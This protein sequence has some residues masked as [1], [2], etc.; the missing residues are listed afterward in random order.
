[1][2]HEL[3]D[4]LQVALQVK[5]AQWSLRDQ[6]TD[7]SRSLS[8][9]SESCLRWAD[10]IAHALATA[11]VPPDGRVS[12]VASSPNAIPLE[13]RWRGE[14]EVAELAVSRCRMFAKWAEE[15]ANDPSI[16]GTP[17]SHLL[18]SI[19]EDLRRFSS[20]GLAS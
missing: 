7:L 15:R 14:V 6:T 9:L 8:R 5:Q 16:Q 2:Q 3:V 18:T 1:L 13:P 17:N 19:A 11:D 4:V 10:Q 20:A 12:T